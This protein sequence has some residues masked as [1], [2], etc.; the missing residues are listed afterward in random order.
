MKKIVILTGAGISAESGIE[1]FRDANGLWNNHKVEDVASPEGWKKN[2]EL[3]LDFYNQR[4][5]KLK[6]VKPNRAHE[7]VKELEE[8]FEVQIITQNIDDLHERAGSTKVLHIHGQLNK[9]CSSQ[10]RKLVYDCDGDIK[11]GDK[12]S[13]G[14]QLRPDIVWFGEDVPLFPEAVAYTRDADLLLVIGTSLQVYPAANLLSY[15]KNSAQLIIINPEKEGGNYNGRALYI[16]EKATS[17]MQKVFDV[18]VNQFK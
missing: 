3:V 15:I 14:A 16:Q 8:H 10:N 9:M 6:E 5:R 12:A 17:G 18:L 7:I 2:K 11:I 4:R 1:T 13:D